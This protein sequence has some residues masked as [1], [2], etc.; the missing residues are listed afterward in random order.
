MRS[1]KVPRVLVTYE[2]TK[3]HPAQVQVWHE[4]VKVGEWTKIEYSGALPQQRVAQLLERVDALKK[5]VQF[6]REAA[7]SMEVTQPQIGKAF[8]DHVFAK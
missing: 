3:E 2:A 4:D 7:N 1:K 5:A 6:A 8:F